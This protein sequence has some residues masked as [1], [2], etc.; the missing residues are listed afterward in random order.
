MSVLI[1]LS[2]LFS[3]ETL[4][5]KQCFAL[6]RGL[7]GDRKYVELCQKSYAHLKGT[8]DFT[9]KGE[10]IVNGVPYW[11]SDRSLDRLRRQGYPKGELNRERLAGKRVLDLPCGEGAVVTGLRGEGIDATGVDIFLDPEKPHADYL[12]SADWRH[13]PFPDRSFDVVMMNSGIWLYSGNYSDDVL[14]EALR[15]AIRVKADGGEILITGVWDQERLERIADQ[16]GLRW[17]DRYRSH[18][19]DTNAAAR[20]TYRFV[21][22]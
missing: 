8:L 16:N 2:L 19:Q 10:P 15:E 6:D 13:L 11:H 20:W 22:K 3:V 17:V 1:L 4:F 21:G 12:K 18:D 5:F 9:A 14:A 7:D